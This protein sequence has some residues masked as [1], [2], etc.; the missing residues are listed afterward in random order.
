M[1]NLTDDEVAVLMIAAGGNNM[2]AIG[3]WARPVENLTFLGLLHKQDAFNYVI[4]PN[5]RKLL[6]DRQR[7]ENDEF[8][9]AFAQLNAA[10]NATMQ[11]IDLAGEAALKLSQAA[12]AAALISGNT[13]SQEVWTLGEQIKLRALELLK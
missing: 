10:R 13:P 12:R 4:T 11:S 8:K 5:G 7:E 2:L 6:D 1:G 9:H 3:R